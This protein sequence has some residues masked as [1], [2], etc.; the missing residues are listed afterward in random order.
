MEFGASRSHY[1]A[2][3]LFLKNFIHALII[4]LFKIFYKIFF[5]LYPH[6]CV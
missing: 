5:E 1:Y 6:I 3:F 4:I 2:I